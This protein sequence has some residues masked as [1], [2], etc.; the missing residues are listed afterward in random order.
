MD[1]MFR[2]SEEL[3][4]PVGETDAAPVLSFFHQTSFPSPDGIEPAETHLPS[5]E[6][7]TGACLKQERTDAG[8]KRTF[9]RTEESSLDGGIISLCQQQWLNKKNPFPFFCIAYGGAQVGIP[10]SALG[11]CAEAARLK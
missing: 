2:S 1:D 10:V 7:Q 8:R 9:F 3:L 4:K 5:G 6:Q 11:C